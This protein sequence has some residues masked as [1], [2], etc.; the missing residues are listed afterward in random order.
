[1]DDTGGASKI[2]STAE[3]LMRSSTSDNKNILDD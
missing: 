1:M 3:A 2:I